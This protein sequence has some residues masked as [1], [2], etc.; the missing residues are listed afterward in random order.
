MSGYN[1]G[2]AVKFQRF[3]PGVYEKIGC[4]YFMAKAQLSVVDN[5]FVVR[6]VLKVECC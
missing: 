6:D 4:R 1:M 2:L 5:F 3:I